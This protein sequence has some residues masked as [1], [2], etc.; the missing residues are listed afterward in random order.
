VEVR[1]RVTVSVVGATGTG[2][3]ANDEPCAACAG[4]SGSDLKTRMEA[5]A[6][7]GLGFATGCLRSPPSS[8]SSSCACSCVCC[9]RSCDSCAS[10]PCLPPSTSLSSNRSLYS[11]LSLGVVF[12]LSLLS[13]S[14]SLSVSLS[15][16]LDFFLVP[17][18]RKDRRVA[19]ALPE[20]MKGKWDAGEGEGE[21]D[22]EELVGVVGAEA[23]VGE[24]G[25]RGLGDPGAETE[26]RPRL[27]ENTDFHVE[28][29]LY[30]YK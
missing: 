28:G 15:L 10:L 19:S 18:N 11:F 3:R 30:I 5:G 29:M 1:S 7:F 27:S 26:G 17:E 24:R 22:E 6:F 9:V 2:L 21:G 4:N 12:L 13:F 14:L 16:S 8:L 23:E 20:R 25:S